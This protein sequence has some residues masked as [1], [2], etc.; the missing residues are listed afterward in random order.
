MANDRRDHG[1]GSLFFRTDS[2]G[3]EMWYAKWRVDGKQIKRKLGPRKCKKNPKG[4]GKVEA[5][6]RLREIMGELTPAELARLATDKKATGKTITEVL[7]AYI[8]DR[9]DIKEHTTA[10]D[11][12]RTC[13]NW[14]QPFFGDRTVDTFTEDDGREL[15]DLMKV[16]RLRKHGPNDGEGLKPKS[17]RN[18]LTLLSSLVDYA[19]RRKWATANEIADVPR[20]GDRAE[21][22]GDL[23]CLEP[24]EVTDLIA[25]VAPGDYELIDAAMYLTAAHTG[26]RLSEL[27][28]L[29]WHAVD[30]AQGV[31]RVERGHTRGTESSPKSRKR[32][33]VP[34]S[35]ALAEALAN[36]RVASK[37]SADSDRVF[38]HPHTGEAL[39]GTPLGE[40]F[41]AAR[42]AA[43]V[44]PITFHG[45]RHTF[46]TTLARAGW[47]VGDIQAMMGHADIAT[48]Q[49]YMHYAPRHDQAARIAAAFSAGDPRTPQSGTT[50]TNVAEGNLS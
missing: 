29:R 45:L 36:L 2:G 46:G 40:R 23:Q 12:R 4:M 47:P 7:E 38:A 21:E 41:T 24:Y 50:G 44:T 49:I 14:F 30:F 19:V 16:K 25:R 39:P 43:G 42:D 6:K 11:Y 20:P 48:T 22:S 1:T 5:E 28:A 9:E 34:L 35:P 8:A 37:W 26:L 17:I 18:H 15:R 33:S 10:H 32:R 31:V 3:R 27:R 13:A